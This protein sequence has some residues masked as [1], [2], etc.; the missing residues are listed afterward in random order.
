MT[1]D[2]AARFTTLKDSAISKSV[3]VVRTSAFHNG[4]ESD[5]IAF[6]LPGYPDTLL[7]EATMAVDDSVGGYLWAGRLL[8]ELGYISLVNHVGN[9]GGFIQAGSRFYELMPLYG[10]YQFLTERN[11]DEPARC[12]MPGTE[13]PDTLALNPKPLQPISSNRKPAN[14]ASLPI[15]FCGTGA[16]RHLQPASTG[17]T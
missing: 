4:L 5:T 10:V 11:N 7:A 8:N 16:P 17:H 6:H 14:R 2:E 15:L 3:R 13:P 9:V 12:G 1:F